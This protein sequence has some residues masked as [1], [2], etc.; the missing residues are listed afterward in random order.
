MA[1]KWYSVKQVVCQF[2]I[3]LGEKFYI[4]NPL[5][6]IKINTSYK[7]NIDFSSK[8]AISIPFFRL[9]EKELPKI[10]NS[11]ALLVVEVKFL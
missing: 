8:K 11:W 10:S 1:R 5:N 6:S 3:A 7:V 9:L 2:Y 4:G